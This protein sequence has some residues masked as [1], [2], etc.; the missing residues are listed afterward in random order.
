MLR[1]LAGP[2]HALRVAA[3]SSLL[4]R[5]HGEQGRVEV[6]VVVKV[7]E[8]SERTRPATAS[9]TERRGASASAG[10]DADAEPMRERARPWHNDLVRYCVRSEN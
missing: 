1:A 4:R 10:A 7:G 6:S 2:H 5:R 9:T 8:R 3:A